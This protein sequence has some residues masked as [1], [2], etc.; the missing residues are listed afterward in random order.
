MTMS[1]LLPLAAGIYRFKEMDKK[2]HPFIYMIL[3]DV[4]IESFLFL[5]K[6]TA[7]FGRH[8][9]VWLNLYMILNFGL[10]LMLVCSNKYLGKK[11]AEVLILAAFITGVFNFV[12]NKNSLSEVFYYVLCFVSAAMLIISIDILSRQVMEIKEKLVNNF[13]FWFSSFSILYNAMNLL[14]FGLY[15]FA[16]YNSPNGEAIPI[17][18]HFVNV[19]C[20]I[21]FVVAVFKIPLRKNLYFQQADALS[22]ST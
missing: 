14:I 19:I 18:Q 11:A 15:F 4:L 3:L 2:F 1:G 17:I 7:F 12:Y 10:F 5:Q 20:N 9:L 21:F 16:M 8:F 13:W 6:E 22:K